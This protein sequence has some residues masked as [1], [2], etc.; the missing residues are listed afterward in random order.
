[1]MTKGDLSKN[2]K[3]NL[4]I[5]LEEEIIQAAKELAT[6]RGLS[7]SGLVTQKLQ[8]LVAAELRYERAKRHALD[9]MY[10]L[11]SR[12]GDGDGEVDRLNWTREELYDRFKD[13]D[14]LA[15]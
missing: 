6:R 3:R 2:R 9:A 11:R 8:E 7:V 4:T 5:Q 14:W 10:N 13:K 1:M 15:E 12:R